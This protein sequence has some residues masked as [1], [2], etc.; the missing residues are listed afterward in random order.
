MW[1]EVAGARRELIIWEQLM[2]VFLASLGGGVGADR[3]QD[4]NG[5]VIITITAVT[6]LITAM[7]IL[8]LYDKFIVCI[9]RQC[10]Y[11]P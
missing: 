2:R 7:I 5:V 3:G 10:R 4:K 6:V 8:K 1:A 9:D 11:S